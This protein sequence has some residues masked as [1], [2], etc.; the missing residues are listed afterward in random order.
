MREMELRGVV[1]GDVLVAGDD[2]FE[3]AG[4]TMVATG[5]PA[6]VVR[7]AT[8]ADVAA[9]LKFAE[10]NDLPIAVRSGGHHA[11]GLGTND[12]GVVIDVRP[13]DSVEVLGDGVVRIGTGATWGQ[14]AER[15]AKDGLAISSGDTAGVG[16]GGLLAGGGIGW[17]VRK[18]GLAIDNVIAAELVTADGTVR[19]V[20]AATD[21]ELF[22][23]VRGAAGSLGV[24][25]SYELTAVPQLT[26]HYGSLLFPWTQTE[27]A[28][29]GWAAHMTEAPDELTSTLQL[30]PT[31][32]ADRQ[33][34]VAVIACVTGGDV[35]KILEPLRGLGT[36]LTDK[37]A[38]VPY[39]KVFEDMTMPP[40]FAPRIRNGLFDEWSPD[41]A[42]KLLYARQHLPALAMEI[43]ALGG[44][45]GAMPADATAFAHR[46]ARFLVNTVLLDQS[47]QAADFDAWWQTLEPNGAYVNF[48]SHPTE[49]DLAT[50]YPEPHRTRLAE[51][52]QRVDPGHVF[53]SALAVPPA[54]LD[55]PK[56]EW[57]GGRRHLLRWAMRARR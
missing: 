46:D 22:W 15:L 47:S 55:L 11:A 44:A 38:E 24:V 8:A 2:G 5:R 4:R 52:K 41:L 37:V 34:P 31:M 50:C 17:M 48:L 54:G 1:T 39:P 51:L 57:T 30:A 56:Q 26:V 16:V 32:M 36:L 12:G 9:A 40:G 49:A 42:A 20:D 33:V 21:P 53:R 35:D 13:M 23:G 25:T 28:L 27:Q 10:A 14:V 29:A 3:V 7:C 45:Y 19:R 43:R 6:V 18:Y